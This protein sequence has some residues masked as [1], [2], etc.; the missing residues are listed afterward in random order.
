VAGIQDPRGPSSDYFATLELSDRAFSTAGDYA[1]AYMHQGKRYHH[2]IDPRTGFPATN[3]K[4]VTV[5]AETALMAD[6]VD[7]SVF[8]LGPKKGLELVE[9]L[10]GVG[11]VVVDANDKV[12]VSKRL[13]G[14]LLVLHQPTPGE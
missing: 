7:D 5:W 9:S 10:A 8:I 1:R 12:W 4:S 14:K 3:C 6:I 2:I 13:E 11:A